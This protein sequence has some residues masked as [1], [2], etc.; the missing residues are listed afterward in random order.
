MTITRVLVRIQRKLMTKTVEIQT[1]LRSM[2][3][4]AVSEDACAPFKQK[5]KTC[6]QGC[7]LNGFAGLRSD[8]LR[9]PRGRVN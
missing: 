1:Y 8:P 2:G 9:H 5:L 7:L 6:T 4:R 3:L